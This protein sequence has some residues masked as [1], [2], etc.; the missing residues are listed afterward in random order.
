MAPPTKPQIVTPVPRWQQI[1]DYLREEILTGQFPAGQPLPSEE[2]LAHEFSVSRP[3]VRQG[4]AALVAEGLVTVSRPYGSIVRDPYARPA[5]TAR[6]DL[7]TPAGD[8][9]PA[10][11]V[12]VTEPAYLRID[13]SAA[14]APLLGIP[15]G[16]PMLT[17]QVLQE[18]AGG[19]RRS[20]RLLVPFSVAAQLHTPWRTRPRLPDPPEFYTWMTE[21]DHPPVF[22]EYVRARMPVGDETTDLRLRPGVPLLVVTRIAEH[23]R[24]LSLEEIRLPGDEIELAYQPPAGKRGR[25]AGRPPGG[26]PSA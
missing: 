17:R 19:V 5:H 23:D 2:V 20:V 13:A 21:H 11:W 15:P 1:T 4:V 10:G 8:T 22:T 7:T 9:D 16:Q 12:D 24:P 6:R 18:S 14:Q 3:T 25:R 26:D